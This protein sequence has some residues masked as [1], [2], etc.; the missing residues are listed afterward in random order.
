MRDADGFLYVFKEVTM[1]EKKILKKSTLWRGLCGVCAFL[2]AFTTCATSCAMRYKTQVSEALGAETSRS[3][4]LEGGEENPIYFPSAYGDFT[5]EN[6]MKLEADVYEHITDEE[7]EGA[8]LMSNNG[9]LPLEQGL[10]VS[11]FGFASVDPLYHT[12]GA[13]SRIYRNEDYTINLREALEAEGYQVNDI[14]YQAYLNCGMAPRT[15]SEG[16]S[17][18]M[19]DGTKTYMGT[20]NVE[21][22]ISM[23]TEDVKASFK[24]Y[25]D[26]AIVMLAREAGEGRDMPT[27]E[28]DETTGEHMSSLALHQNER[29]MLKLVQENFEHI[30]VLV[31]MTYFMELD[32][33]DEYGVD[34]CLWIGSPGNTGL[35]GVAEILDGKVNPSG[36]LSD[37]WAASSLSA[38]TMA[39][40]C[41][42]LPQWSNADTYRS[43]GI[44]MD[45]NTDYV[46]VQLENIYVGYKYYET[47]YADSIMGNGNAD[48]EKGIFRSKGSAWNYADEMC[49][50]F[51][52]GLSYTDFVQEIKSVEYDTATDQYLVSVEVSNSGNTAGKC[53]VLVYA[54]TPYGD[55][56]K[57][58]KVEKSAIQFVGYDKTDVIEVG[59]KATVQVPV[60]RYLLASYDTNGAQGYILSGGDTYFAV[61]DS[62]HDAL[63]NILSVQG[64]TGMYNQDGTV[65]ETL[66]SA[67]VWKLTEGVPTSNASPDTD[68]YAYSAATGNRVTNQFMEQDINHWS[69]DTGV[70][71]TYLTRSDWTTFPTEQVSV[72]CVGTEMQTL[73]QGEVYQKAADAISAKSITQGKTP[74]EYTF[75]MMKDVAYDDNAT[76]DAYLDQLTWEDMAGQF[77]NQHK[78]FECATVGLPELPAGDGDNGCDINFPEKLGW[79]QEEYK[80]DN[81][82]TEYGGSYASV[83][84]ATWNKE[85]QSRRGT[86]MGEEGLFQGINETWTGGGDL[87]RTPFGGR[88]EEYYSE[89]SN[90]CYYVGAIELS[91][92]QATGIIAGPKHFAGNDWETQRNGVGIFYLEQAFREGSL[93]GFEGALRED[94]GGCLG[95]MQSYGRQGLTYTPACKALNTNVLRLEWGFK[96]NAITDA[97][98]SDYGGHFV[99]IIMA[100]TDCIC[101][102]GEKVS[103]T[104]LLDY[105]NRTDDGD[106][107]MRMREMVK[108]NHYAFSRS[109][110][111]NGLS[112]N[113]RIESIT[114]GW[115]YGMYALNVVLAVLTVG[116]GALWV[117]GMIQKKRG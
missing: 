105:L 50:T 3:V 98:S 45:Q 59:G 78:S 69:E 85:L 117:M 33:L 102:D 24:D 32:W 82:Y 110:G 71:V 65:D 49:F 47:R 115:I 99:D 22:P 92:M 44:I 84:A 90:V 48:S 93:R 46:C 51:G 109:A 64:Y 114:P 16:T 41:G 107:L 60:D 62:S 113:V 72:P 37:T 39:N 94:K 76:W 63:N 31:N 75:V 20:G 80:N 108:N 4:Y 30:V 79:G 12:S 52:W 103:A 56:E 5:T 35:T 1:K 58:N 100:G 112:S 42:N 96:G 95:L 87:R 13:G 86:L 89:D 29:N 101:F 36:R 17:G 40:S 61:G 28:V 74:A 8:V 91:A 97:C 111:I 34:A 23:Y 6:L 15:T 104:Y 83:F 54:Q 10:K 19:G 21:A 81:T 77:P 57:L 53:A 68:A 73:L 66:N 55:Y 7:R 67:S 116:T 43:D 88:N 2:L 11:L 18:D 38:P 25:N 27:D 26:V 14:L 70:T 9:V 106:V